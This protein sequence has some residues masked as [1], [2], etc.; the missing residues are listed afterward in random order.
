MVLPV[1]LLIHHPLRS[2][3]R[4]VKEF[5][6]MGDAELHSAVSPYRPRPSIHPQRIRVSLVHQSLARRL[7]M[8]DRLEKLSRPFD[9]GPHGS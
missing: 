2:T 5:Q 3:V 7:A 1:V 6:Q 8:V 4:S 9:L